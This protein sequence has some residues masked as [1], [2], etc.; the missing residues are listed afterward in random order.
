MAW[1]KSGGLQI[2]V[3][4]EDEEAFAE[5]FMEL[6]AGVKPG[7]LGDVPPP[8]LTEIVGFLKSLDLQVRAN[9]P[10]LGVVE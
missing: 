5:A 7:H 3:P 6:L 9:G 4:H 1:L 8:R 10:D 2:H